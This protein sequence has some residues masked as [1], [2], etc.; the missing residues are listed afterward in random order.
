MNSVGGENTYADEERI[1]LALGGGVEW[2]N[3]GRSTVETGGVP[4]GVS[5][6][7]GLKNIRGVK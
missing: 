1:L 3:K 6:G 7:K 4:F 2:G 5:E